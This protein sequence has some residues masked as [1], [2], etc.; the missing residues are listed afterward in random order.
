M[1]HQRQC[2][3]DDAFGQA[4]RIHHLTGQHEKRHGQQREAVGTLNHILRQDLGVK[5][6]QVPHQG[7]TTQQ[8]RKRNGHTN[9]HG[10]QQGKQEYGNGHVGSI[11]V[12]VSGRFAVEC[13]R[14]DGL[15]MR[16]FFRLAEPHQLGIRNPARDQAPKVE[17]Q[18][19]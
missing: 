9:H 12:V 10:G 2:Q 1:A 18:N 19:D 7:G 13:S 11:F 4:T 8:Q 5:H 3:P 6:V 14:C 16:L 15:R 17:D